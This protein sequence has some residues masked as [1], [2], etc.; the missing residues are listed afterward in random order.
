LELTFP[1]ITFTPTSTV[2]RRSTVPSIIAPI[3]RFR[4]RR[5]FGLQSFF[6]LSPTHKMGPAI[7]MSLFRIVCPRDVITIER[8]QLRRR[9]SQGSGMVHLHRTNAKL[10]SLFLPMITTRV[11]QH[12]GS[13]DF[14]LRSTN[15]VI[16]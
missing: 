6:D 5:R 2:N 1:E 12:S 13:S 9:P 3:D 11:G 16:A 4:L 10:S 15:V 8:L 7:T 14:F